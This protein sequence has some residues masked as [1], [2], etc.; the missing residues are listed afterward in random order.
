MLECA[1]HAP[2]GDDVFGEDP[3]VL[4]LEAYAAD[5]FGKERALFVPTGTMGNLV[6]ILAHCHGR[7]SE[8]I[9]G[10]GSH[11]CLYEGGNAANLGGVHT[12]Q[13]PENEIDGTLSIEDVRDLYRS[14]DDD[15]YA[16]TALVCIENTHN[17]MGGVAIPKKYVDDLGEV[18]RDELK[19]P[20]HIDGARIFNAAV[21][22][23]LSVSDL[24]AGADSVSFCL[25]KGL[26]APL[27]SVLV[28]GTEFIRLAKRARKRCGGGMRQA[29]VVASMGIYALE[30][31][32]ER[33]AEDHARATWLSRELTSQGFFLPRGG[34]VDTNVIY[35]GL[36]EDSLVGPEEFEER[37]LSEYGVRI[38]GGYSRKG[39]KGALFRVVT[40]MDVDNEGVERAAEGIVNICKDGTERMM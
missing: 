37:L 33:L 19:I 17:L 22:H 4:D 34:Q 24:C 14:D 35:F 2:T 36:P 25:S 39:F 12:R 20:L 7:A 5:L 29:G 6:A 30:H 10:S 13:I 28:G 38:S 40:H 9:I 32:V 3:T 11:I 18:A 27:G 26:G 21:A 16:Q 31:N 15:H 23:E 8:I 1:I